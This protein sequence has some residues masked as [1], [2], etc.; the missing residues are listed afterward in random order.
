MCKSFARLDERFFACKTRSIRLG[1][2]VTS[3]RL[4]SLF[5]NILEEIAI[6]EH[7]TLGHF[8]TAFYDEALEIHGE[9]GNFTALLRCAC[10]YFVMETQANTKSNSRL[11]LAGL[12]IERYLGMDVGKLHHTG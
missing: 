8:L 6:I 9:I 10:V 3:I 5:W 4:E 12:S 7:V 1:G 2:H 11:L